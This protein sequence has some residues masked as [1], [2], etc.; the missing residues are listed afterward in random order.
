[1]ALLSAADI[2]AWLPLHGWATIEVTHAIAVP[3]S[4]RLRELAKAG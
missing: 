3:V 4:N 1:M 2:E